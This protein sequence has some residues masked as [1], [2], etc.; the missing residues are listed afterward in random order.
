MIEFYASFDKDKEIEINKED[1]EMNKEDIEMNKEDIEID[2]DEV[3]EEERFDVNREMLQTNY[4]VKRFKNILFPIAAS[5]YTSEGNK[6][7]SKTFSLTSNIFDKKIP[8]TINILKESQIMMQEFLIELISLAEDLLKKRNPTNSLFYGDDKVII[9]M[10]NLSSFDGFFI[11]QTLLKSRILNYTFNLNKKLK[12]TSYEGLIY[13]I[14]IGNLCFQDSYR[15]IPMSLNKLSFL[16]LNKQKKDFDVE[17][18]NSQKLQHIFKNKEILEK[19]LEYCLYDSILLY[20]SMIL[21]QKTFWDEL[22]FDITSESTISNTAINFFFSKY[23]EFPTQYYWHTTTKKDGLSAKLKYD[24]KRVTV[25][26]HHNAI[27]YTKPFLDQQLRSAYFGGRTE[28][29]KP[30]TSNGYVFD[31]NS[32]Y[33]FALMYDMPY[34]SPIYEN[35]YKNWTTNEFESFFGFLKIIFITP[36]NYDILPVLPR[37][38]PPPISHNV[39]CLGIGEGWYFS[40]EIKL[41]RQKGYKLKILESI[42]FTPHKGFEKFVRDF[43]SIR[44]QYPKGHPLNLLAKLI[45]NSTYGRFGIALTTHKQMKTFNQIKLKEKKNKKININI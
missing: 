32:L 29:Y 23:Y 20:E 21:I 5:F 8:S 44:Q 2:L 37:R 10:H 27:F 45:L 26:T 11:L 3:N 22:K 14:K 12:V 35:E 16:L 13:R 33:A 17:N 6:N 24:N 41:A 28:L 7:V 30:Q 36:P 31:I 39:Y 9:Y 15:V 38:Y 43:F 34:G 4:F 1:S 42:K 25:S 18:I 40:E 19:M